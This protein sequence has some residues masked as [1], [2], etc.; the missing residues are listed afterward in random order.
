M[1]YGL[2]VWYLGY[3]L[4]YYGV[5]YALG[6]PLTLSDAVLPWK[7]SGLAG[8]IAFAEKRSPKSSSPQQGPTPPTPPTA[9]GA[10]ALTSPAPGQ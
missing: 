3:A 6:V 10:N 4:F 8:A 2:A 1:F 7:A 9:P 5:E